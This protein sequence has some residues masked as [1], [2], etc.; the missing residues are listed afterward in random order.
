MKDK[1]KDKPMKDKNGETRT[2]SYRRAG[3]GVLV[4]FLLVLLLGGAGIERATA[5]VFQTERR[6]VEAARET[7]QAALEQISQGIIHTLFAWSALRRGDTASG[8]AHIHHVLNIL[9]GPQGEHYDPSFGG[10]EEGI[11]DGVGALVHAQRLLEQIEALPGGEDYR[12]AAENVLLFVQWAR[13]RVLSARELAPRDEAEAVLE[14]R[15]AQAMLMAAR[16]SR[17]EKSRPTEGGVRTLLAWLED[18]SEWP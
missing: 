6:S 8:I 7:A 18:P 14:L 3:R 13:A 2:A 10:P 16:G 4:G 17:E 9:E 15:R 1:M 5:V 12:I 11:G